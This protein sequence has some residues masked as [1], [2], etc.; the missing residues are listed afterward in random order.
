LDALGAQAGGPLHGLLHGPAE[1]DPLLQLGGD[2]LG[3]Q[4][5]VQ[6]GAADLDDVQG[7]ALANHALDQ[8]PQPLNLGAAL[9]DD[10]ARAG[11]VDV[12]ADLLVVPLNLNLGDAGAVEGLLQVLADVVIFDNQVADFI[13]AGIPAGVPV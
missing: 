4:L 1:G 5:G 6:V 3:H 2:V 12:D 11:A 8:Q 10:H 9:A 13:V 7:N